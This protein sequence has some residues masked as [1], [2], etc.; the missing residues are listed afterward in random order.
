MKRNSFLTVI[1]A[2]LILA[3]CS[4]KREY[5]NPEKDEKVGVARYEYK[6]N[7]D[8]AFTSINGATLKDGTVITKAGILSN[9]KLDKNEKFLGSSGDRIISSNLD[10]N[11]K[12]RNLN[13]ETTYERKFDKQVVS[14]SI[15][16]N[17]LAA[18]VADNSMF[19]IDLK[20]DVVK[21]SQKA[22]RIFTLD[23]RSAAPLFLSNTDVFF[24]TLDG[25]LLAVHTPSGRTTGDVYISAES[26]FNNVIYF[27][28]IG[29]NIYAATNTSLLMLSP[30][31]NKRVIDSIKNIFSYN[32]KIYLFA[33]DGTAKAF[34]LNLNE[35]TTE[36]FKFA[37]FSGV[38]P[39]GEKFYIFESTGYLIVTDLNFKNREIYKLD[40]KIDELSFVGDNTF[41]FKNEYLEIR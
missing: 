30:N 40:D 33:K 32:G 26:F 9:I 1:L 12:I 7:N 22:N 14:A 5:F 2:A 11:F 29:Q 4:T 17:D 8:I 41:Y 16:G 15:N 6:L 28:N 18:V 36:K 38:I 20:S 19:L 21:M 13:G 25:Q 27:E 39:K 37:Q 3:G 23:A 24:P 10:G 31:G 35:L 34:D